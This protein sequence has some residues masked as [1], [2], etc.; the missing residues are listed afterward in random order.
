M[1]AKSIYRKVH[2]FVFIVLLVLLFGIFYNIKVAAELSKMDRQLDQISQKQKLLK[3]YKNKIK[4]IGELDKLNKFFP[5]TSDSHW[6]ITNINS[7]AKQENIE[8]I[9]VRPLPLSRESFYDRLQVV[10]EIEGSYHQVGRMVSLIEGA[11]RY[12]QIEELQVK[13]VYRK[14]D[15]NKSKG[16]VEA[17][18]GNTLLNWQITITTIM[19]KI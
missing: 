8:I 12:F 9:S 14:I 5:Q 18:D 10:L 4:L 2:F 3:T 6:L 16:L 17:N 7:V 15:K 11:E 1:T 19:P 13:P